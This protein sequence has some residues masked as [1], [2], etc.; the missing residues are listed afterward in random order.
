[1]DRVC[2]VLWALQ[3]GAQGVRVNIEPLDRLYSPGF[4][5]RCD[6]CFT[7]FNRIS[8]SICYI[9]NNIL[10]QFYISIKF[11]I[12]ILN[13]E[14]G[15]IPQ[16]LTAAAIS[17]S[18]FWPDFNINILYQYQYSISISIFYININIPY[19][20]QYS[21]SISIF[22]IIINIRYQYQHSLTILNH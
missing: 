12:S 3:K 6:P 22:Y 8:I 9:N 16:D 10:Y 18:Q 15:S 4:N 2:G 17:V 1:M 19:R 5:C 21:I 7:I 13:H 11:S 14:A 20:Y